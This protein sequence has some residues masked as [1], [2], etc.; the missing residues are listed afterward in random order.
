M[1]DTRFIDI[2]LRIYTDEPCR[3]CGI[4]LTDEDI[5][6]GAI[7]AGYDKDS[8]SRVAHKICWDNAME[9][10]REMYPGALDGGG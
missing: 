5:K 9:I 10:V 3:I 2:A 1:D 6:A 7:W 4:I 8:K